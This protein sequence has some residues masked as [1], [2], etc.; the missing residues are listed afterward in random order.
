MC[1]QKQA[2]NC[3]QKQAANCGEKQAANCGEKIG[4]IAY[5]A[6]DREVFLGRDYGNAKNYSEKVAA[7]I[8]AEIKDIMTDAYNKCESILKSHQDKLTEVAEYL[9]VNEKADRKAF[10][11]IMDG[12]YVKPKTETEAV[13][14]ATEEIKDTTEE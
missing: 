1:G 6:G 5:G 13:A 7:D 11:A 12:T 14:E 4:P 3:G 9:I 10:E 8:D 2:A